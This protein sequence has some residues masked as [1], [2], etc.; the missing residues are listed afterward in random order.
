MT[1]I[2]RYARVKNQNFY[3]KKKYEKLKILSL[4]VPG[5]NF[6][7]KNFLKMQKN[8]KYI[9]SSQSYTAPKFH[10]RFAVHTPVLAGE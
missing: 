4:Y 9:Y 2:L 3:L 7:S 5:R 6:M 1:G 10:V 8:K